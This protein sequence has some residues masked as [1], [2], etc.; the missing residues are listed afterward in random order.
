MKIKTV[1]D[2]R[3][4][5]LYNLLQDMFF[6]AIHKDLKAY[7][8][9]AKEYNKT[10]YDIFEGRKNIEKGDREGFYW[11]QARNCLDEFFSWKALEQKAKA[12]KKFEIEEKARVKQTQALE[13]FKDKFKGLNVFVRGDINKPIE[14]LKNNLYNVLKE[15]YK[16]AIKTDDLKYK[17]LNRDYDYLIVKEFGDSI[18]SG[19]EGFEWDVARNLT[20]SLLRITKLEKVEEANIFKI[21]VLKKIADLKKYLK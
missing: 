5:E 17:K 12:E 9:L 6:Q 3:K 13:N 18:N 15:L 1:D 7:A 16:C 14:E 21:T 4:H 20:G 2:P 19:N 8:K 11:D 10:L